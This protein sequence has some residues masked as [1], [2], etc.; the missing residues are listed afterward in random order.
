[1]SREN[2]Q[3]GDFRIMTSGDPVELDR[4]LT[5][6]LHSH[7]ECE[8]YVGSDSQ[9]LRAKTV[10]VST[11]VIRHPG[12]GAHVLYTKSKVPVIRDIFNKLWGELERSVQLAEYLQNEL[13]IE[14]QQIDLDYN[15]DE[16]FPSN[17]VLN[18][19]SGYV[20]SLGYT[21]KAKPELLMAVWAA[22]VLCN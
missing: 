18:A 10:Y 2:G 15:A 9:N 16:S 17:K 5:D 11:I 22:N 4:Y 12:K 7:P 21:V 14:V 8:I 19:A 20:Q 1:M 6:Y 3:I 13:L